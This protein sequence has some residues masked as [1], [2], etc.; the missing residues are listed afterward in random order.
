MANDKEVDVC[1]I[2]SGA[3]GSVMAKE[4]GEAGMNVVVLESG[5]RYNP[6]LDYA[7]HRNEWEILA[8]DAFKLA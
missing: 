3:G 7:M 6:H 4:L 1:I 2:G 8:R 5:P